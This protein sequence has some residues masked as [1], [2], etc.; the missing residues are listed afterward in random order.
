VIFIADRFKKAEKLDKD[1]EAATVK[2]N[3]A[4][5]A[6]DEL[7]AKQQQLEFLAVKGAME[8]HHMKLNELPAL[9][10]RMDKSVFSVPEAPEVIKTAGQ[11]S[12]EEVVKPSNF[13]FRGED[14]EN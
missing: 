14:Y 10:E 7:K 1:I 8:Q 11:A 9:L 4:K 12:D 13:I 2:F 3:A 5:A 6:L